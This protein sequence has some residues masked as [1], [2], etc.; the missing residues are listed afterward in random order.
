MY[1]A[2]VHCCWH[3]TLGSS[4]AFNLCHLN[5]ELLSAIRNE[6][7][8]KVAVAQIV[9]MKTAIER[10]AYSQSSHCLM[11]SLS[12]PKPGGFTKWLLSPNSRLLNMQHRHNR[13]FYTTGVPEEPLPICAVCLGIDEHIGMPVV[14]CNKVCGIINMRFSPSRSTAPSMSKPRDK[15]S[16]P[17]D[18]D[19]EDIQIDTTMHTHAQ[20][21]NLQSMKLKT[22]VEHR[23]LQAQTPYKPD[24]WEQALHTAN[25]NQCF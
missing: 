17:G 9:V 15:D 13:S 1:Q 25:P 3:N 18:K 8:H 2:H 12:Y 22:A 19:K 4:K 7:V 10:L 20:A 23:K 14:E 16:A 6:M 5:P 11:L 24:A 21:V